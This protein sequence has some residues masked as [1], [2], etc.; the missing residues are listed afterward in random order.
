TATA[1][2]RA[3]AG[4]Y[5]LKV[6]KLATSAQFVSNP[7]TMPVEPAE[8]GDGETPKEKITS[9]TI[10]GA[11]IDIS[12]Y[13][14][15]KELAAGVAKAI[16]DDKNLGISAFAHGKRVSF[17]TTATGADAKIEVDENFVKIFGG[18]VTVDQESG[19][20][21]LMVKDD[22]EVRG[23]DA[24]VTINKLKT[25]Q[26]SN[27]FEFNGIAVNLLKADEDATIRIEV[28]QDV[29]A[30]VDK[31]KE[32]VNMYNELVDELNL[33]LREKAYRD[34]PP[35]TD[36]Q[37]ADLSDKEIELWEEKAKSG[38]LRSDSIISGILSEMRLALGG[39]VKDGETSLTLAQIGITTGAWHEYGRLNLNEDKLRS[40]I[41][42]NPDVVR[43]LFAQDGEEGSELGLSRR[44]TT[45]LDNGMAR[46]ERTAGK[47]SIA[48]DQS[49][50]GE[51]IREYESRLSAMEERLLRYEE[52]QWAKFAAMERVLGQLYSQGDWLTQ[53]LM[54]LQG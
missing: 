2:G 4:T 8:P 11:K 19:V 37:R 42:E 14:T 26:S 40:A 48:F 31:V 27:S 53:Q 49:F 29:D 34:F 9:I 5:D 28:S 23:Q 54:A 3:Q 21:V 24:V 7:V 18:R 13:T 12:K 32:F 41:E 51:R 36:A 20:G 43:D 52:S 16:N 1:T 25:E 17:T 38:L 50:L 47:A 46:L 33:A 15:A 6:D 22:K 10:N 35:L 45:A 30:V 39:S 44:I